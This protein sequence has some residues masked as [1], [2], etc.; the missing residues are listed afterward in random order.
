MTLD[1][2]SEVVRPIMSIYPLAAVFF[3]SFIVLVVFILLSTIIGI[4]A[5][6]MS[7]AHQEERT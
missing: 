3:G 2:W 5:N 1:A 7:Y 6:A 4:A